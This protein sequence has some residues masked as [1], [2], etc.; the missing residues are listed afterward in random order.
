VS[1]DEAS[2]AAISQFVRQVAAVGALAFILGRAVAPALRGARD[3]LDRV[4][5]YTDKAGFIA[6]YLFAFAGLSAVIFE[7]LLTF[8]DR[9]FG[10]VY[11]VVSTVLGVCVISL[12]APAFRDPLPERASIV[13]A[14]AS[15]ML[16]LMASR[17]AIVVP[18]TRALGVLLVTAGSAA[19]MHLSA[20]LVAWY[21]GE[22]AL[23]RLAIFGRVLATTSVL[24]DTLTL[25]VAFAWLA[26]R[27]HKSTVWAARIALFLGCA[28][29]WGAVRGGGRES[30]PLWELVAYRAVDRLLPLPPP[31]VWLPYRFVLETGAP[32]LAVAALLAR[33]QMPAVAGS[34]ALLLLGRPSTD[35]PLSALALTLAA[36]STPLA[37]RDDRGMWAVLMAN[38]DRPAPVSPAEPIGE[39]A[40][41]QN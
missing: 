31:Y 7:L 36:L 8:R 28:V 19:L 5:D 41:R 13:A 32:L 1:Q 10:T 4:I 18:R 16:A 35:V 33:G 15:G 34:I 37:A 21:A 3:G 23:Y 25:L 30:S 2:R 29:A 14:L 12:V 39:S 11:R 38:S 24:F 26:T 17:E 6:T 27:P 22:R 20:S 9:R 40:E